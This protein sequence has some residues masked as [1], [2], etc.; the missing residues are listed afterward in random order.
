MLCDHA[1]VSC[2]GQASSLLASQVQGC[3]VGSANPSVAMLQ[4]PHVSSVGRVLQ[5]AGQVLRMG[6]T[7]P[8][9]GGANG[10]ANTHGLV[11]DKYNKFNLYN[12]LI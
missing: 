9:L 12:N 6:I 8:A 7:D 11:F 10:Q 2:H 3:Q 1:G 4:A 5:G